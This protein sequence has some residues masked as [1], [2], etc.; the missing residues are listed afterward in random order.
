MKSKQRMNSEREK[1]INVVL[2]CSLF[3]RRKKLSSQNEKKIRLFIYIKNI[4]KAESNKF[5]NSISL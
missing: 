1:N 2:K 3:F 4:H 5:L